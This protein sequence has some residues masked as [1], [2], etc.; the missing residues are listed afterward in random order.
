M[1]N[2]RAQ[3][4]SLNTWEPDITNHS[5]VQPIGCGVSKIQCGT[6]PCPAHWRP[7]LCGDIFPS[8]DLTLLCLTKPGTGSIGGASS[9]V[10]KKTFLP[11]EV[12]MFMCYNQA[13]RRE[14]CVCARLK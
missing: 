10:V 8:R 1:H 13:M 6:L 2:K 4:N 14:W 11:A 3:L 12:Y 9:N 5:F 7:W